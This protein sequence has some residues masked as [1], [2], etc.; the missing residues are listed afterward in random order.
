M[1]P[2]NSDVDSDRFLYTMD[3]VDRVYYSDSGFFNMYNLPI[4]HL[5]NK[6]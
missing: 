4:K 1:T 6:S 3:G 2:T 5:E